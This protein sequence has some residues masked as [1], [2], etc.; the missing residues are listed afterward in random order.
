MHGR[1][2]IA[3]E[4]AT[5]LDFILPKAFPFVAMVSDLPFCTSFELNTAGMVSIGTLRYC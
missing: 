3:H 5:L 1:L 2:F 4:A